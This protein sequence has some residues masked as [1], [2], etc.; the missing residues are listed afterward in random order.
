MSLS[1]SLSLC[2]SLLYSRRQ[3]DGDRRSKVKL[4]D[5]GSSPCHATNHL[6]ISG[7]WLGFPASVP[8][9]I[10]WLV[11]ARWSEIFFSFRICASVWW[12]TKITEEGARLQ[13]KKNE[14]YFGKAEFEVPLIYL[15]VNDKNYLKWKSGPCSRV[16]SGGTD[17]AVYQ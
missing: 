11:W 6:S 5:L 16:G 12:L 4:Q 13:E 1:A 14:F 10:E 8:S 17:L 3:W 9:S 2:L 15:A 7:H